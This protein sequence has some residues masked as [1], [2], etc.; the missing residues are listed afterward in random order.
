MIEDPTQESR[1]KCDSNRD[2]TVSVG[3]CVAVKWIEVLLKEIITARQTQ[4]CCHFSKLRH[5]EESAIIFDRE[6]TIRCGFK[7]SC[8]V[9][10]R[11]RDE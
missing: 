4:R 2:S 6:E 7:I 5:I 3:T 1:M 9:A 8:H 11:T 10:K